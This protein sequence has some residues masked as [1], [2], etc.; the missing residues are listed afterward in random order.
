MYGKT[1][2]GAGVFLSIIS[3]T[4]CAVPMV[5]VEPS[6][7]SFVLQKV[8]LQLPAYGFLLYRLYRPFRI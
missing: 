7:L 2:A 8:Q 1:P 6:R 3:M 4:F 5:F